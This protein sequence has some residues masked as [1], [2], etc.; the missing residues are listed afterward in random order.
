MMPMLQTDVV[1]TDVSPKNS[2][3]FG[4]QL[5]RSLCYDDHI[6]KD[7]RDVLSDWKFIFDRW[8]TTFKMVEMGEGENG[9]LFIRCNG[10]EGFMSPVL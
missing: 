3:L 9:V 7:V 1:R 8:P 5:W 4:G 10:V 2:N 6:Y